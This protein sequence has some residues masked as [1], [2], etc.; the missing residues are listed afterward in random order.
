MALMRLWD[1]RKDVHSIPTLVRLLSKPGLVAKL[2]ERER[3]ASH[4]TRQAETVLGEGK[5][6]LAFSPARSTPDQ[7]AHELRAEVS[8]WLGKVRTV[9]GCAE[10]S[11]LQNYRHDILAHSAARSHRPQI[12]LPHYGDEQEALELTI[13]VASLGFRLATGIDHDFS[14]NKSVWDRSQ[15]DMWEII[16]RGAQGERYSPASRNIDDLAREL[17]GKGSITIK[18]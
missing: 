3:Q 13:P 18:G 6:E 7:R 2:V 14:T 5:S 10:I 9:Q 12:P 17:A 11:R 8:S 1:E 15:R 16:R 4:D